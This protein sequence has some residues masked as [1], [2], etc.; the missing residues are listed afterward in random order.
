MDFTDYK[1]TNELGKRAHEQYMKSLEDLKTQFRNNL[2]DIFDGRITF[3]Q[4]EKIRSDS[5]RLSQFCEKYG[6][7]NFAVG[8]GEVPK[9]LPEGILFKNAGAML[10][11]LFSRLDEKNKE[12]KTCST[13]LKDQKFKSDVKIETFSFCCPF[14]VR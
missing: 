12:L 8:D 10:K 2:F 14:F 3:R 4:M 13:W 9:L 6:L 7:D 1:P 11:E 5:Y